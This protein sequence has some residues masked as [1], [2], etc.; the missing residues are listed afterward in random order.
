ME[1]ETKEHIF[2]MYLLRCEEVATVKS[3]LKK[4]QFFFNL[5]CLSPQLGGKPTLIQQ[6]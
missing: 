1:V 4:L 2:Q 3:V 5:S 6:I